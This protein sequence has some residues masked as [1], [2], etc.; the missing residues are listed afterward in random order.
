MGPVAW[1]SKQLD[2]FAL[3]PTGV[4]I[5]GSVDRLPLITI[6]HLHGG[7]TPWMIKAHR[8]DDR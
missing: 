7:P 8:T 4:G 6:V 2:N 3:A 1:Q 5:A